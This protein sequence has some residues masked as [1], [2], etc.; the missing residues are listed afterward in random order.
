MAKKKSERP[1]WERQ[2]S[3]VVRPFKSTDNYLADC[4]LRLYAD[5]DFVDG[6]VVQTDG[7]Q[8]DRLS[9][10]LKIPTPPRDLEEAVGA[11]MKEL[12]LLV[13]L[14]DRTFKNS[15][16]LFSKKMSEFTGELVEVSD[17]DERVSWS[18]D[19]RVHV[20]LVLAR[21][22]KA[23]VGLARRAGS[24]LARKTFLLKLPHDTSTFQITP[25]NDEYFKKLGLPGSTTYFVSIQDP[26]LN[27][28]PESVPEL[29]K[30][31]MHE[32]VHST[33]ARDDESVIAKALIRNIYVDVASTILSAGFS[34]VEGDID[35]NG[36][37]G[38]VSKR[39]TKVTG[40][41]LE[42]LRKFAQDN[43]G[44]QLRAVIQ[45]EAGLSKSVIAAASRRVQ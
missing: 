22:R 41:G 43:G 18:N 6:P 45:A 40:I 25:V 14:E 12:C 21:N 8:R 4:R 11:E 39:I 35:P 36:I 15:P 32:S 16:V 44:A 1:G 3:R 9:L 28:P 37:L 17:I 34:S 19:T 7:I 30:V 31:Y 24:W 29:V 5:A 10:A 26:D 13:S 20:A 38:L 33:L 42:K 23:G 2:E 27:Q